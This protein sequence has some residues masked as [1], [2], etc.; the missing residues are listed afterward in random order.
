MAL[1]DCNSQFSNLRIEGFQE[2][3]QTKPNNK[4]TRIWWLACV[5]N[6]QTNNSKKQGN[7][8]KIKH[9]NLVVVVCE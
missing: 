1:V 4:T 3:N 8:R 9:K 2:K 7:K 5:K 6:E